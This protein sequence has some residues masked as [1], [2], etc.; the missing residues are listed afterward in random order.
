MTINTGFQPIAKANATILILGS[1]PGQKSLEQQQYYAHPRN[2]FWPIM[3]QLFNIDKELSYSQRKQLLNSNKIALWDV[4]KSC[5][6]EGSLDSDIDQTT[7]EVN[8]F[9]SFFKKHSKIK[10]VFFNGTKAEQ[11]F[12]KNV[13]KNLGAHQDLKFHKLPSTSPAHAAMSFEQKLEKW[14]VIKD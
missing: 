3:V 8:D 7:I 4:L 14:K 2:S 13:L 9:N 1:M 11:L 12:K 5:H 10:N 6:R